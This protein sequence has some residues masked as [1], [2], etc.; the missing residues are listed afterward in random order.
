MPRAAARS[1]STAY[2]RSDGLEQLDSPLAGLRAEGDDLVALERQRA[3]DLRRPLLRSRFAQLIGLRKRHDR[4]H[5][6]FRQEFQHRLIIIARLAPD[7]QQ[8]DYTPKLRRSPQ[9]ALDERT[10]P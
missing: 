9:I 5:L 1:R 4:R 3:R 6:H 2:Q 10:P 8:K 7:V